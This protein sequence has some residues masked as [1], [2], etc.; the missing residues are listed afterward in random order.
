MLTWPLGFIRGQRSVK[1]AAPAPHPIQISQISQI[2]I[3]RLAAWALDP[4]VQAP[5]QL[6]AVFAER[7]P[8]QTILHPNGPLKSLIIGPCL[9]QL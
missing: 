3:E 8:R 1:Q 2:S 7:P 4:S 6:A 5:S 9:T